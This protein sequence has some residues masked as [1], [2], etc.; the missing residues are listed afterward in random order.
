MSTKPKEIIFEDLARKK[1]LEGIES[2]FDVVSETLGPKGRNIGL[3]TSFGAPKIT[4]DGNSII[5]D[6]ELKDPFVNMGVNLAKQMAE[7]IKENCGDGTTT[8]IVLLRE[9]VKQAYKNVAAGASPI[10]IK[11]GLDKALQ[12]VLQNLDK[13]STPLKTEKDIKS[14]ATV[15]ASGN[16]E[17]GNII[18]E[19]FEKVKKE[20]I[21]TIEEGKSVDTTIDLIEGMKIDRGYLSAYF[22]TNLEKLSVEMQNPK[23]LITDKKIT[24]IQEILPLLQNIA[25]IQSDFLIIADDI[26]GDILSTLVINKLK[27]ILKVAAIKA[28]G[29]GDNK[30]AILEDIATL[31]DATVISEDT[32]KTLK[33]TTLGDLGTCEK[34]TITKDNTTFMSTSKKS[35][36]LKNRIAQITSEIKECQSSYEK[37]KLE[38]R[39]A[40][41]SSGVVIIKVGA[42][43]EMA[44]QQKKQIFEDSLNATKAALEEGIVPGGGLSFINAEKAI[45]ELVLEK[46]EKIGADILKRA[47]SM[48]LKQ[49]V[50]NSGLEENVILQQIRSS[51]EN[52]G[53]NAKSEKIEN[54]FEKGIVDPT[55]MIKSSLIHAVSISGVVILSEALIT[56]AKDS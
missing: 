7:K 46:E 10:S 13:S 33:N 2:V 40:K 8:G 55:K 5:S 35:K 31:L 9:I 41:L 24:S 34:I 6:I 19:S 28:P 32:T 48:P 51:K 50:K 16:E 52:H 36:R 1:L 54:L 45:D 53:F 39:K 42:M 56:D 3:D 17:I 22:C 14:I 43:T 4:N 47:L 25:A 30:K 37:E 38:E 21:I 26:E 23:I 44:M 15:S 12:A 20:G 11:R 49:I 29:F 18:S 27:N